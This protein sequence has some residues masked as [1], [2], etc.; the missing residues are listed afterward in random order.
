VVKYEFLTDY[1]EGLGYKILKS[2]EIDP[3]VSH[4]YEFNG[5]NSFKKILEHE[6]QKLS[7]CIIYLT[8][9][10]DDIIEDKV[11]LTWYDARE[12]HETRTEYRLYYPEAG[13]FLRA[14]PDDLLVVCKNRKTADCLLT[15]FIAKAGE[16]ISN[17]LSWLFGISAE[18]LTITG[19]A[20]KIDSTKSMN[21]FSNLILTKE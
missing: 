20:E 13:C 15:M 10:E 8:D 17:Q 18:E 21:Y 2:V 16:L 12:N 9:D 19:R 5:I 3:E 6:K 4:E 11:T 1:F 7:C 14:K